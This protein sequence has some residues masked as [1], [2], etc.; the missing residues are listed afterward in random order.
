MRADWLPRLPL[1]CALCGE[2]MTSEQQLV[3]GHIT[4]ERASYFDPKACRLEHAACSRREGQ[5]ISTANK[6]E[7]KRATRLPAW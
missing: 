5:R 7:R 4:R 3:V 6:A 1:P 2:A